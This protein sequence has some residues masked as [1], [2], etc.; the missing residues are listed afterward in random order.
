MYSQLPEPWG[1]MF[2]SS[3]GHYIECRDDAVV[4]DRTTRARGAV[5]NNGFYPYMDRSLGPGGMWAV[6]AITWQRDSQPHAGRPAMAA[7]LH[8]SGAGTS[9]DAHAECDQLRHAHRDGHSHS[10]P[11]GDDDGDAH[12][13]VDTDGDRQRVSYRLRVAD[14]DK[15][16]YKN[17]DFDARKSVTNVCD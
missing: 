8:D 6:L 7:H 16:T 2:H 3:V 12:A 4:C 13:L 11:H 9:R 17:D 1:S 10:Q 5:S 15:L 14:C